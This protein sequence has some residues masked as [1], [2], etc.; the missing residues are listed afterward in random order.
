MRGGVAALHIFATTIEARCLATC[1]NTNFSYYLSSTT[2]RS[3]CMH[4][5]LSLSVGKSRMSLFSVLYPAVPIQQ[6]SAG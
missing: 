1:I 6:I 3:F 2:D 5:C 4:A